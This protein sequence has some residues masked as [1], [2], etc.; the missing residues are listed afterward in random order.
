[1]TKWILFI[2]IVVLTE[3]GMVCVCVCVTLIVEAW[4]VCL[5]ERGVVCESV[6][7]Q[8]HDLWVSVKKAWPV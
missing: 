3:K 4:L 1:M 5:R 6:S 8:R 7:V 2:Y